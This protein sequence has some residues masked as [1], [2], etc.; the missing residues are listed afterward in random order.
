MT[1]VYRYGFEDEPN[2]DK[3]T[4]ELLK[5]MR[6]Q[7]SRN[8]QIFSWNFRFFKQFKKIMD[9]PPIDRVMKPN[10]V[11]QRPIQPINDDGEEN[12]DTED[13]LDRPPIQSYLQPHFAQTL[14]SNNS[15]YMFKLAQNNI[16]GT[17]SNSID[18][19][20]SH[21]HPFFKQFEQLPQA[22]MVAEAQQNEDESNEQENVDES[23]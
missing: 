6:S 16:E 8:D 7:Q 18:G 3:I 5:I 13:L 1:E 4:D 19:Q 20:L 9:E 22:A 11:N 17:F 12:F 14:A 15:S 10:Q 21:F 2:Y 23:N